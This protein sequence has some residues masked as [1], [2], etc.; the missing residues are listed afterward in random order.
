MI[1]RT[2]SLTASNTHFEQFSRARGGAPSA[3][4][5]NIATGRK[6]SGQGRGRGTRTRGFCFYNRIRNCRVAEGP[7]NVPGNC[8]EDIEVILT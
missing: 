7:V 1:G 4:R 8:H 5:T 2:L 6:G 3:T